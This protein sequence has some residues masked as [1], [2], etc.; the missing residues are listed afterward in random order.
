MKRNFYT[1]KSDFRCHES[2][3][4]KIILM[5]T[6][7]FKHIDSYKITLFNDALLTYDI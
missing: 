3:V 7:V 1:W 6:D 4:L 2:K 5:L